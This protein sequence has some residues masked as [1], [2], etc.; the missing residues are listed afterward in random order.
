MSP[1]R[2]A[3]STDRGG[4]RP[5]A[6]GPAGGRARPRMARDWPL[7]TDRSWAGEGYCLVAVASYHQADSYRRFAFGH[8][9][10]APTD[11]IRV[12]EHC[13]DPGSEATESHGYGKLGTFARQ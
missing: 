12:I 3:R 1:A 8:G 11:R 13:C 5:R 7:P 10:L 6:S 2:P 4:P 9:R